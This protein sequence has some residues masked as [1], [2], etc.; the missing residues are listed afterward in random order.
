MLRLPTRLAASLL[1]VG[2]QPLAAADIL[3]GINMLVEGRYYYGNLLGLTDGSGAVSIA[4]DEIELRFAADRAMYAMDYKVDADDCDPLIEVF[5]L[6]AAQIVAALEA[7]A[8]SPVSYDVDEAYRRARNAEF[9]PSIVKV[10]ADLPKVPTL[11]VKL[12]TFAMR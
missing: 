12:T 8:A 1:D 6:S 2:G 10:W 11:V 7:I 9:A 3:V 5:I 4:R